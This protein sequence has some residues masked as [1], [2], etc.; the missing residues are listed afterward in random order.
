MTDANVVLSRIVPE[1]FTGEH[2]RARPGGGRAGGR[3]IAAQ[4]GHADARGGREG[5]VGVAEALM[6]EAIRLVSVERGYDPRDFTLIAFGGAGPLHAYR[7][8]AELGIP[9]TVIPPNPSVLSA[10]GMLVSDF[11]HEHRRTRMLPLERRARRGHRRDA[12]P[13]RRG[14]RGESLGRRPDPARATGGSA[15]RVDARYVGQSWTLSVRAP[16]PRAGA[17]SSREVRRAFDEG[18]RRAY[19]YALETEPIELVSF[20]V[21]G[22]GVNRGRT[23]RESEPEPERRRGREGAASAGARAATTSAVGRPVAGPALIDDR[24]STTVVLTGYAGRRRP[25]AAC[26]SSR[27]SRSQAGSSRV[28][29]TPRSDLSPR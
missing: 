11:R 25:I 6:A 12:R 13:A 29:R 10:L 20:T 24:G 26:C 22:V 8:A 23:L 15:A 2:V 16:L 9:R 27:R 3:A 1:N 19:G 14:G 18:H 21:V 5:V 7:L 28:D 17:P 4:L